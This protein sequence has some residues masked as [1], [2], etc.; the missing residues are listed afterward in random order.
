MNRTRALRAAL[1][2][3]LALTAVLT[4]VCSLGGT[5]AVSPVPS[6]TVPAAEAPAEMTRQGT[7]TLFFRYLDEP[8]LAPET[9]VVN[10]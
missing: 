3:L 4:G 7:A 1:I 10:Q 5:N 8:Y 2:L 6:S 9:R